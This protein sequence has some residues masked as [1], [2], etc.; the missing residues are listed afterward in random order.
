[1][2]N[3]KLTRGK[4]QVMAILIGVAVLVALLIALLLWRSHR[5]Y[6]PGGGAAMSR[7]ARRTKLDARENTSRWGAGM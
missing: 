1:M 5:S 2:I 4:E 3:G 6:Q 7:M